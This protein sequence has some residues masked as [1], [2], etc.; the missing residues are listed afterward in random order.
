MSVATPS[1]PLRIVHVITALRVGGA[2]H[3]LLRLCKSMRDQGLAEA[4][5][6]S[7]RDIGEVGRRLAAEGFPV[8]ALGLQT[9]SAIPL[10]I[11]KLARL[12]R[13]AQPDIVQTWLYHADFIGGVAARLSRTGPVVW[14]LRA[15]RPGNNAMTRAL[16]HVN[17]RLSN[18]LPS[19]IL[20]CGAATLRAHANIGYDRRRLAV[21][22]NGFDLG[23]FQPSRPDPD[24]KEIRFVAI[25]RQDEV[26]DFPTF[27]QAAAIVAK[28]NPSARFAIYGR[29]VSTSESNRRA[30]AAAKLGDAF[31]LFEQVGDVRKVIG[32]ADVF[33]SSSIEEGFPNVLAEA[34]L[35]EVPCITTRAGDAEQIVGETGFCVPVSD[36]AAFADAMNRMI[37]MPAE[38]RRSLGQKARERIATRYELG[39]VARLYHAHYRNL[40]VRDHR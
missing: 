33:C 28:A 32:E 30:V 13:Q 35:M 39:H 34:M 11:G 7:V 14:N 21:I 37:A 16:M 38:K 5:I 10:A 9:P 31:Q 2:E 24:R 1:R 18:R 22:P 23:H 36:V 15:T 6:I 12:L 3:F 8:S 29:G 19:S 40:L 26:K 17:A 4:S 20:S 27:I 25:G